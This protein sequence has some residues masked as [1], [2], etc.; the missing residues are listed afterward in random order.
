MSVSDLMWS[1][2]VS[3]QV[4]V[5]L[6]VDC[7]FFNFLELFLELP[8]SCFVI[9]YTYRITSICRNPDNLHV[10]GPTDVLFHGHATCNAT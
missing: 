4:E 6:K 5:I 10:S 8:N 9:L 7:N 1:R 2:L 3:I